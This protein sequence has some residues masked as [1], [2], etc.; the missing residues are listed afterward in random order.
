VLR[1][2]SV[3]LAAAL[4]GVPR[5]LDGRPFGV[6]PRP[7][8]VVVSPP[9]PRLTHFTAELE[10]AIAGACRRLASRPSDATVIVEIHNVWAARAAEGRPA[11]AASV[12]VRDGRRGLHLVLHYAPGQRAEA[13]RA[14]IRTLEG[15]A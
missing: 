12:T 8:F 11:E 13:A 15:W 6:S 10:R 5:A 7:V 3:L 4:L 1:L 9:E 14:L 2:G